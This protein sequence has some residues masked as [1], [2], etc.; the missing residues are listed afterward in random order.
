ML[1]LLLNILFNKT[2]ETGNSTSIM[3]DAFFLL[4]IVVIMRIYLSGRTTGIG[5]AVGQIPQS[6]PT[7]QA[8]APAPGT[9]MQLPHPAQ[10]L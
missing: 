4:I 7:E 1:N 10:A 2:L 9:V 8:S 6:L 5:V 3:W